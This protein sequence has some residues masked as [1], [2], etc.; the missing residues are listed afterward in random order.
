MTQ[1]L[2][3]NINI[4]NRIQYNEKLIFNFFKKTYFKK[5]YYVRIYDNEK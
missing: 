5:K 1:Y 2:V 4:L 3:K